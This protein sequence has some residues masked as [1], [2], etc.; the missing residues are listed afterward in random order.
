MMEWIDGEFNFLPEGGLN[1]EGGSPSAKSM[2]NKASV[3]D[4][5]PITTVPLSEFAKNIV[6]SDDASSKKDD[7]TLIGRFIPTE[8]PNP[9]VNT[10][11]KAAGNRKQVVE[12]LVSDIK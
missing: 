3:I 12:S 1:D 4:A 6:D 11:F 5:E 7:M 10:S 9:K 8:S 2:N